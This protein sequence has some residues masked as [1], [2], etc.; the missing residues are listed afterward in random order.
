MRG[1]TDQTKTPTWIK[2]KPKFQDAF[3]CC[4]G[5]CLV[6]QTAALSLPRPRSLIPVSF[7]RCR[8]SG[9]VTC[10]HPP[11]PKAV[12]S[13]QGWTRSTGGSSRVRM[14]M[15]A[16]ICRSLHHFQTMWFTQ[17]SH[18]NNSMYVQH[19]KYNFFPNKYFGAHATCELRIPSREYFDAH[20]DVHATC[21]VQILLNYISVHILMYIPHATC[22]SH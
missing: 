19:T 2:R 16:N 9:F 15:I 22:K 14:V 6:S 1:K 10:A 4:C 21:H 5:L 17:E 12:V 8:G 11:G 7:L 20:F 13:P 3:D 18:G